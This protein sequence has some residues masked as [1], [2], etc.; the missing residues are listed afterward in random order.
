MPQRFA[1]LGQAVGP[2][3]AALRAMCLRLRVPLD[4]RELAELT[5]REQPAVDRC[6]AMDAAALLGLLERCDALRRPA[7]CDALLRVCECIARGKSATA[8]PPFTQGA[9]LRRV[10]HAA[11]GVDTAGIAAHAANI[12]LH[13]PEVGAAI[14]DA[15]REAIVA[16]F[17]EDKRSS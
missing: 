11:L 9:Y 16:V 17:L 10:L 3:E 13:G 15:R 8:S 12:G 5:W 1:C 4:C 7:R 6:E 2:D 14:H